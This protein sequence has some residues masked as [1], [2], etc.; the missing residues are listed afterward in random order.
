MCRS[1]FQ[2][3]RTLFDH[4]SELSEYVRRIIGAGPCLR[5]VLHRK[6]REFHMLHAFLCAIVQVPVRKS[7][8]ALQA[9]DIN[10]VVVV[11][12]GYFDLACCKVLDRVVAS[13]MAEF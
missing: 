3:S 13:V 6:D 9:F 4:L 1:I 2:S 11:L 8:L 10:A 12:R 5:V 7:D